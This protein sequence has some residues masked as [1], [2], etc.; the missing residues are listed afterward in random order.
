M[1][2][3]N[4]PQQLIYA[5]R[6][7][8]EAFG[9]DVEAGGLAV[10]HEAAEQVADALINGNQY[11]PGVP[12]DTGFARASFRVGLNA[13]AEGPTERPFISRRVAKPG[14]VRFPAAPDL[15]AITQAVLGDTLYITTQA[16]YPAFLEFEPKRRRFGRTAGQSTEF[17]AP[18]ESRWPQIVQDAADRT[19][20]GEPRSAA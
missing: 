8:L 17:I 7:D 14:T 11:G 13:P 15:S 19:G 16:G 6:A 3:A 4:D 18:V 2:A 9:A 10:F 5:F 1:S 12:V 20:F